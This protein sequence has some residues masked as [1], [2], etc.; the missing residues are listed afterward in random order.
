MSKTLKQLATD[1]QAFICAGKNSTYEKN[2]KSRLKPI[3][4]HF[5]EGRTLASITREDM[6]GFQNALMRRKKKTR[7]GQMVDGALSIF[8]IDSRMRTYKT[9]FNWGVRREYLK[10][11]PMA[12]MHKVKRPK[13][14][15]AAIEQST[16]DALLRGVQKGK[17]DREPWTMAR[18]EAIIFTLRD[19]G[20][21]VGGITRA[22]LADLNL[23]EQRL[24]VVEKGQKGRDLYLAAPTVEKLRLYLSLRNE[25]W[26]GTDC[27]SLFI[28]R[29]GSE[30]LPSGIYQMLKRAAEAAGVEGKCNPHSFRHAFARDMLK[31]GVDLSRVSQMMGHSDTQVTSAYYARWSDAELKATHR[32][33][34]PVAR[35]MDNRGEVL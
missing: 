18:D 9:M 17:V 5:G 11:N 26:K 16:V 21:R 35:M 22:M 34:S 24:Y 19:T 23:S 10:A 25:F 12:G 3:V 15:P 28:S 13:K 4:E 30:L 20:A 1:Y 14:A 32:R 7:G 8:T 2:T 33:Y 29:Y 31:A 6:E 27:K